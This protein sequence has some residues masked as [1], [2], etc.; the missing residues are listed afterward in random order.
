MTTENLP[1]RPEITN[2]AA[3]AQS[4]ATFEKMIKFNKGV[5]LSDGQEVPLGTR[6]ICHC[7]GWAKEWIK[8]QGGLF[9]ERKIYRIARGEH[10]PDRD[11][12]DAKDEKFWD[13]G[14]NNLPKDPWVF[15]YLLPMQR[16]DSDDPMIFVTPSFG[17]RRA[18][19][20]L[21]ST[22]ARR[23]MRDPKCGQPIVRLEKVDMPT[24][25]FGN[26]PRPQ[27]TVVG[28]DDGTQPVEVFEDMDKMRGADF[29]DEIP[30]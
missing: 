14:M 25:N 27:F 4:G 13:K 7:V 20:D 10:A 17:C 2:I 3:E 28:W 29:D 9:I 26:V 12:L 15:R 19:D 5:Y 21:C 30:F 16:I 24:K 6:V 18:V 23:A 22:Y 11:T 1:A 8:F